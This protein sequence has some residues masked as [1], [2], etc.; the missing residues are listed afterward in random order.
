MCGSFINGKLVHGTIK[1]ARK[2]VWLQRL[3]IELNLIKSIEPMIISCD[4]QSIIKLSNNPIFH[5]RTKHIQLHHHYIQK[6]VQ[7][8]VMKITHVPSQ[9]QIVDIFTKPLGCTLFYK[10]HNE[11]G[12][13]HTNDF[14]SVGFRR[15]DHHP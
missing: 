9:D 1:C 10:F 6:Q 11:L 12:F 7:N 14:N 15:L 13:V 4:N 5:A 8:G 3:L 2:G